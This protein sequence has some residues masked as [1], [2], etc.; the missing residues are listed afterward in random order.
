MEGGGVAPCCRTRVKFS[1]NLTFYLVP[2][3]CESH[4]GEIVRRPEYATTDGEEEQQEQQHQQKCG[5]GTQGDRDGA[6]QTGEKEFRETRG[7]AE[8][9]L[10][11]LPSRFGRDDTTR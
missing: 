3:Y 7:G 1:D 5:N 11:P 4:F 2:D 9:T 10:R 8:G 6:A